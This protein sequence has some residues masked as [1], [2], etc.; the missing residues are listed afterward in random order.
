MKRKRKT[1]AL[2]EGEKMIEEEKGKEEKRVTEGGKRKM[3]FSRSRIVSNT[4]VTARSP[5]PDRLIVS[6]EK[7]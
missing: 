4:H 6:A 2:Q 1:D 5:T 3:D 7:E